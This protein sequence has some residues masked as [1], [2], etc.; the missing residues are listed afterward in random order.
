[1]PQM[2]L[3]MDEK[4]NKKVEKLADKW[5]LSKSETVKKIIGDFKEQ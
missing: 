2:I 5:S 1:M 3:Y 4:E